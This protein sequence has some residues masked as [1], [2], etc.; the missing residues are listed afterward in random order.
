LRTACLQNV[1]WQRA[2]LPPVRIAVNVS[3]PQF[4]RGDLVKVIEDVLY[5]SQMEPK[6]LELELTESLTLDDSELTIDTMRGLKSIGVCLSLDD[7]GT[8]WSSLS[9]LRRLPLDRIKI[10]RSFMRDLMCD[11]AAKAVVTGIIDLS[12]NLGF[13]CIA[14]GVETAEQLRYLEKKNCPEIQ[15]F[16]FSPAMPAAA[17]ETLMRSASRAMDLAQL[18]PGEKKAWTI[19]QASEEDR[20]AAAI[21]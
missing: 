2:G 11:P 14:E 16:F 19:P 13:S 10:D 8:G 15:G 9:C 5:E 6:W 17:C 20:E 1:A 18:D 4:Y 3:A 21:C 7:F 12:R